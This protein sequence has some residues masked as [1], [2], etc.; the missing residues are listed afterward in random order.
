M[1][2][3]GLLFSS[4]AAFAQTP[5]LGRLI[6]NLKDDDFRVRTQAALALGASKNPRAAEPLCGV[7]SDRSTT[8]RAAAAAALGRL[9]LGGE[10]CLQKR[11]ST[12]SAATVKSAIETALELLGGGEPVFTKETLYYVAVGKLTDKSGRTTPAFERAVRSHMQ[13]AGNEL[14]TFAFA[15]ANE[16][17]TRASERLK[18]HPKVKAFFLSPRLGPFV[19]AGGNLT[20]R[21]EIAIFSYPDKALLGNF[22]VPLTQ[23]D[24][25]TTDVASE[26]DLV[27]MAAERCI[28]KF[29]KIALGL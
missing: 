10:E 14:G 1:L 15:P 3:L 27:N 6:T 16:T 21:L 19:Y 22:A 7:L 25:P 13:S 5:D 8:V 23:E 24:V 9:A 12:E 26:N 4:P 20:V 28:V 29:A 18:K 2:V 17:S 11:L